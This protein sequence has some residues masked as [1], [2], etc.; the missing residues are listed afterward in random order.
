MKRSLKVFLT[1]ACFALALANPAFA[2]LMDG[3]GGRGP[4]GPAVFGMHYGDEVC[5]WDPSNGF[6]WI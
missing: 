3:G 4:C 6:Y 2:L 1:V 5:T